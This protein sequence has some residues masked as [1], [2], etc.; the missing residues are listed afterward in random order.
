M[1][2]RWV[3]SGLVTPSLVYSLHTWPAYLSEWSAVLNCSKRGAGSHVHRHKGEHTS[4]DMPVKQ[5]VPVLRAC[6][7]RPGLP[8]RLG[9]FLIPS[10]PL[11]GDVTTGSEW[12]ADPRP[13][14]T[15]RTL[16]QIL[17]AVENPRPAGKEA[18]IALP[19]RW[20]SNSVS[21]NKMQL[22]FT[23]RW[24]WLPLDDVIKAICSIMQPWLINVNEKW[25][26]VTLCVSESNKEDLREKSRN[27][28]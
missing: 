18:R 21:T 19:T 7:L 10:S 3:C 26:L 25:G 20:V 16:S 5:V 8:S 13:P 12:A 15:G 4:T 28:K 2:V 27:S 14:S 22:A 23:P 17:A 9:W 11:S 1:C 6:S 24:L